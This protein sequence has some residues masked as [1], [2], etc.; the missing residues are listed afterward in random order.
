[1]AKPRRNDGSDRLSVAIDPVE[2]LGLDDAHSGDGREHGHDRGPQ[3]QRPDELCVEMTAE[4][5][6]PHEVWAFA[7]TC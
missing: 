5:V 6:E 1:M 7:M 4:E 3:D 2:Y